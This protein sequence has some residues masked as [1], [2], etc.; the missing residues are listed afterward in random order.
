MLEILNSLSFCNSLMN[1]FQFLL[2]HQLIYMFCFHILEILS[3][4]S[5]S[6]FSISQ[7]SS[8]TVYLSDFLELFGFIGNKIDSTCFRLA[9]V[10]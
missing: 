8:P 6:Q 4:D 10:R 7:L 5:H 2:L 9:L 1:V 3:W